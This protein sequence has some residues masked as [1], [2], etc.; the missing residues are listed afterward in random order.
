MVETRRSAGTM[1][2]P[3]CDTIGEHD[4]VETENG[5]RLAWCHVCRRVH[6]IERR[7]ADREEAPSK[8]PLD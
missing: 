6:P 8:N 5:A 4:V 7:D 3:Y 2:C 1:P